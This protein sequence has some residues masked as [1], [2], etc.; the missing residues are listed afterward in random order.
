LAESAGSGIL[1][2]KNTV[3]SGLAAEIGGGSLL[4]LKHLEARDN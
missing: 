2:V 3:G 4:C 1:G